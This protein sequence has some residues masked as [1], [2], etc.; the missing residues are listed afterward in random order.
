MPDAVREPR[1]VLRAFLS[2]P[3]RV[4]LILMLVGIAVFAKI[5][6]DVW[7]HESSAFDRSV[8]LAIHSLDSP[9]MDFSMRLFT[10]LGSLKVVVVA[11]AAAAVD[12]VRRR[13]RRAVFALLGV[14]MAE[15]LMNF[16]LKHLV[17][18]P[19]PTLFEEIA[20]LHTYS[21]PSGHAMTSAAV[22]G[23]IGVV[24]AREH[25]RLRRAIAVAAPALVFLVGVSRVFLGV[26]WPTDVL[27]GWAA[28]TILMLI[29]CAVFFFPRRPDQIRAGDGESEGAGR[30]PSGPW[31]NPLFSASRNAPPEG[32]HS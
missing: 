28:G 5:F 30:Q 7:N 21:F 12:A 14:F 11:L 6:E 31:T 13:D 26:H 2:R 22:Y 15:E 25:R 4:V 10:F 16:V 3:G 1:G 29:G 18:R 23:I 9:F 17:E 32:D 27:A 24:L 8:A 19:R 20:T